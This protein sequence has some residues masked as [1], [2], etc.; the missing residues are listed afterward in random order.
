[1]VR[2]CEK[3]YRSDYPIGV[4]TGLDKANSSK[5]Y[6]HKH[7]K[8]IFDISFLPGSGATYLYFM[9]DEG[10]DIF[11][12]VTELI[13]NFSIIEEGDTYYKISYCLENVDSGEQSEP[14]KRYLRKKKI[15]RIL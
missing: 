6:S 7:N 4:F 5:W 8:I 14:L 2:K 9:I 10:G 13:D 11:S 1:M 15:E 3:M 12:T